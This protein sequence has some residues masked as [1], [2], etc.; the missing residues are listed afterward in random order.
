[1]NTLWCW[2][3]AR[4]APGLLWEFCLEGGRHGTKGLHTQIS[5]SGGHRDSL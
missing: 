3:Q 2:T 5:P 1:M 4:S